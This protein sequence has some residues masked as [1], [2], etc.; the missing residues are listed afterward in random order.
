MN[1]SL[2]SR[3]EVSERAVCGKRLPCIAIMYV[4]VDV[5]GGCYQIS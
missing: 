3:V 4:C 5:L 2:V 1:K